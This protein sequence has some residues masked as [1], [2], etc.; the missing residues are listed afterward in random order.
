MPDHVPEVTVPRVDADAARESLTIA[1]TTFRR[2]EQLTG[3]LRALRDV[4]REVDA[5]HPEIATRV[6]VVDNDPD[7]S[8]RAAIGTD[9]SARYVVEPR[10][11]I[12]AARNRA[13]DEA[14][15]DLL[16]F[17]DDDELPEPGW[18]AALLDTRTR[19]RADAVAGRVV[20]RFHEEIDPWIAAGG[21]LDR[22]FRD[23]VATGEPLTSAA[24][25]NLLLDMR[26]VRRLELRF[27][28]SFGISGGE[29][30]MF[31]SL[32]VR[33]GGR[34]VWCP[35]AVVVDVLSPDRHNRRWMLRRSFVYGTNEARIALTLAPSR[36]ARWV[37]RVTLF[38]GGCA[39]LGLGVTWHL[40]GRLS[41][42][43]TKRVTGLRVCAR[44]LGRIL[45]S[46]GY[47][48]R[49]YGR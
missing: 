7:G 40:Y 45:G 29:D 9:A 35:E 44:G 8:G 39:R 23:H 6:L 34:L 38:V 47:T 32:F 43:L 10:P 49:V 22:S 36:A 15:T 11:G 42:N 26:T 1:I 2:A 41:G 17:I 46:T 37:R 19:Y 12:A 31:T 18:L 48:H 13:L 4:V 21:F 16:V 25:N 3:L 33:H 28:E 20:T 5:S 30:S 24:T 27:D 14:G